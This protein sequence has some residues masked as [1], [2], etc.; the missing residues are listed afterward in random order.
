MDSL[1]PILITAAWIA[2]FGV[3]LSG[4]LSGWR[5]PLRGD[6]GPPPLFRLLEREG[7]ALARVERAVGVSE[8]A[9]A[10]RRCASCALR[11]AC[12]TEMLAGWLSPRPA[13]CPNAALFDRASGP[14][15]AA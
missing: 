9:H 6:A 7:L 2:I 14:R 11:N 3:L 13:G 4:V 8:L 10:A 15:A 1:I 12:E 5:E